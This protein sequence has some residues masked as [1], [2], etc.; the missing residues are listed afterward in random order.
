MRRAAAAAIGCGIIAALATGAGADVGDTPDPATWVTDGP[1]YTIARA[2]SQTFVG[3]RFS[4]VGRRTGPGVPL[5]PAGAANAGAPSP[6]YGSF[7]EVAGGRVLAVAADGV[8]GWF[9]GGD[10]DT[11]GSASRAGLARVMPDGAGAL[12][13]DPDFN[14]AVTGTVH[15][16]ALGATTHDSTILYVGGAFTALG[17]DV[18]YRNF[19]AVRTSDGAPSGLW[20]APDS[21]VTAIDVVRQRDTSTAYPL[22][23]LGGRFTKIGAAFRTGV[24]AL[25]GVGAGT[26]LQGTVTPVGESDGVA[27]VE[28]VRVGQAKTDPANPNRIGAPVYIG[29]G[30]GV[31]AR[32]LVVTA[33]SPVTVASAA[34]GTWP[35]VTCDAVAKPGCATRVRALELAG[36][37]ETLYVGGSFDRVGGADIG[38]ATAVSAAPDVHAAAPSSTARKWQPAPNGEVHAIAAAASGVYLG[39]DFTTVLGA[40]Q[41]GLAAVSP[42]AAGATTNDAGLLAWNPRLA[43]GIAGPEEGAVRA[44]DATAEGVFAGG[45]F[46]AADAS[47]HDNV[48]AFDASGNLID[49]WRAGT[50]GA[51]FALA[52]GNDRVYLG[53]LFSTVSGAPRARLAAVAAGTGAVDNGFA[54]AAEPRCEG[55]GCDAPAPGVLSLA[56]TDQTLYVG[57]SFATL[58]GRPRANAGAVNAV[59]GTPLD[60]APDPDDTVYTLL[61]TCGTVYAGGAFSSAGGQP[62][63]RIAA[64]HPATGQADDWNPSANGGA[65]YSLARDLD[66]VY[67]GGSFSTIGGTE[68]KRLAALDAQSGLATSWSPSVTGIG[69]FV[70][71]IAVAPGG[72]RVYAGGQFTRDGTRAYGAAFDRLSGDATAWNPRADAP[73]RALAPAGDALL[74]GGDFRRIGNQMQHGF[75]SFGLATAAPDQPLSC[76]PPPQPEPAPEPVVE[77]PPPQP[78]PAPRPVAQY[79]D[80]L[81]PVLG[82]V[83]LTDSRFRVGAATRWPAARGA[84]RRRTPVGTRMRYRL[85]EPAVLRLR[86]SRRQRVQCKSRRAKR[87]CYRWRRVGSMGHLSRAGAVTA[88]FDGRVRGRRLRPGRYRMR[89]RAVDPAGNRS[90]ARRVAFTVVRR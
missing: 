72:S 44:L 86:F 48:A 1:V 49:A 64:L 11:V 38:N 27:G 14:P 78:E 75:G 61:A 88:R 33:G 15:A 32:K 6:T 45:S 41:R 79:R 4:H 84:G 74:L 52:A 87:P 46:T 50:D 40:E 17:G 2:G 69:D 30:F 73:V 62:R 54:P 37:G 20:P 29:G 22:V 3:G 68:R 83:R 70:R 57:G 43:G 76:A 13:V 55:L 85:S 28:A 53:G 36:G 39:G 65:V 24:A 82:R 42:S 47:R 67:A 35:A 58:A 56:V 63:S 10:F 26:S 59:D 23:V 34:Y 66:V 80:T 25:W 5:G 7:P 12:V 19:A 89:V 60:W 77:P 9:I 81:A 16:L 8:G 51:V 90:A 21:A 18:K 31:Q 71:A